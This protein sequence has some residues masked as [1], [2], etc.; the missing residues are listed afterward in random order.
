MM[1]FLNLGQFCRNGSGFA[2]PLS[3]WCGVIDWWWPALV[4]DGFVA[5][6]M[7]GEMI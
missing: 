4:E 6:G 1:M 2:D 7:I 5:Q 3:G